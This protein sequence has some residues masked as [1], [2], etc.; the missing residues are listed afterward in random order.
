MDGDTYVGGT[1]EDSE[2]IVSVGT[3]VSINDTEVTDGNAYHY[4]VYA[5]DAL[6]NYSDKVSDSGRP[7]GARYYRLHLNSLAFSHGHVHMEDIQFQWD[8]TWQS[9]NMT[10]NSLGSIGGLSVIL[11][12]NGGGSIH[13]A[14][15]SSGSSSEWVSS[16]NSFSSSPPYDGNLY[17][18]LDFGTEINITGIRIKSDSSQG[19]VDAWYL[20]SSEEGSTW[21]TI[22]ES[23]ETGRSTASQ[24]EDTW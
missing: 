8:D 2:Y 13:D 10:G 12:G 1:W 6:K 16:S 15:D 20:Q 9:N 7:G 21:E 5:F 18:D 14:F 22:P 19:I 3:A 11:T 24:Q 17:V 23:V 4:D